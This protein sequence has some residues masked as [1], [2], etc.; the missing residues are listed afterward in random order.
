[1]SAATQDQARTK[2]SLPE[3]S[4]NEAS[5]LGANRTLYQGAVAMQV[6]GVVRPV[7]SGVVTS[8][9]LG[10][11]LRQYANTTGSNV[12]YAD[13]QQMVFQRGVF[14]FGGLAGDLPTEAL[15]N[16]VN[17]VSF[18]D[19]NTVKATAAANDLKCTLRAIIDG[20][21]FVEIN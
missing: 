21:Y 18:A 2:W 13:G 1:M 19:D 9:L 10:V 5:V 17:G 20:Q 3:L 11:S 7:A 4:P 12:T 8:V 6:A 14:P 16:V 15:I